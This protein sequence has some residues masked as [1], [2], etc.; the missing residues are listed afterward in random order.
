MDDRLAL[1]LHSRLG[2]RRLPAGP[3]LLSSPHLA[4]ERSAEPAGH[5][6]DSPRRRAV[7]D[8]GRVARAPPGLIIDNA[9]WRATGPDLEMVMR[10]AGSWTCSEAAGAGTNPVYNQSQL[11]GRACIFRCTPRCCS[12]PIPTGSER[13]P[14]RHKP[15]YPLG[16]SSQRDATRGGGDP[17]V[18]PYT[19]AITIP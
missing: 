11:A 1:P 3:E 9:N 19:W 15:Q 18:C 13:C 16:N 12:G 10:S 2:N 6:G 17:I 14:S 5:H 7:C 8:V 4:A